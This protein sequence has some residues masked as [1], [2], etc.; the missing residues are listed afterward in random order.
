MYYL[1]P[2]LQIESIEIKYHRANPKSRKPDSGIVLDDS[3]AQLKLISSSTKSIL[4]W[5]YWT[6]SPPDMCQI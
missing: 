4:L 6:Y 3:Q 2:T 1:E 5:L